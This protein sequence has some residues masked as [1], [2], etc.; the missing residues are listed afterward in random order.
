M[1]DLCFSAL[2]SFAA[3]ASPSPEDHV[4][5]RAAIDAVLDRAETAL[6][7]RDVDGVLAAYDPANT[8]LIERTRNQ[9]SGAIALPDLS[10]SH[11]IARLSGSGEDAEAVVLRDLRYTDHGRD[12]VSPTWRTMRFHRSAAGW[13]IVGDDERSFARCAE[14]DLRVELR[15]DLG[16]MEGT[17]A[18]RVEILADGE[19]S[20]VLGLNRGL[21]VTSVVDDKGRA[22]PFDRVA[23]NLSVRD[24]GPLRSG[25]VRQITIAFRGELFNDSQEQGYSQV[26]LAPEG[27]FAS[28]VTYWYPRLRGDGSKSKGKL[29]FTVPAGTI[30]ASN[31][32]L[33]NR[34]THGDRETQVFAV[35]RP[36]DFSFAAAKYF[37][38][39]QTI[40]GM[41]LGVYLLSGG[42]AKADLYLKECARALH[43]EIGFF[44]AYPFD[45]YALV[46]I[47]NE[48]TGGL[49]GS[50]EQGMNLFPVGV[51]PDG[52]FP[53]LLVGH[54]VG[55]S[56][57]GNLVQSKQ[58]EPI[59]DEGLAQTGAALTLRELEGEKAMRSW[60]YR[61]VPEY[62]QSARQYFARFAS[63]QEPDLAL[64]AIASGSDAASA[65]HDIADTK[66]VCVYAMLRDRI[67]HDAFVKA[68]RD[69]AVSFAKKPVGI[70]DLQAA[71]EKTSGKKLDRFFREWFF[72]AGAPEFVMRSSIDPA[73]KGFTVS[74]SV[75]QS[76][77]PYEADA[78]IALAFTGRTEKRSV[79]VDG[80]S[81]AFSF[82]TDEKPLFVAFDPEHKLLRWTSE[83]RNASLLRE[84]IGLQGIG[85]HDEAFEKLQAFVDKAPDSLRGRCQLGLLF[86]DV[87]DLA[88]AEECFRDV[89]DRSRAFDVYEPAVSTSALHLGQVLDLAGRREE[90]KKAYE[91]ALELPDEA[92][93]RKAAESGLAAPYAPTPR[94]EA[95]KADAL[96][97]Y[98]GTYAN[99]RGVEI[100]VAV[101]AQGVL[102]LQQKGGPTTSLVWSEGAKF[103][104]AGADNLTVEFAG[105]DAITAADVAWGSNVFHLP[106]KP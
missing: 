53:L 70:P 8:E 67:G 62:G 9:A 48:K 79:H 80:A 15:P 35:D 69:V 23:G 104:V 96:A 16:R 51:L 84:G 38:R 6:R 58:G 75:E 74:G 42:E 81:T 18:L 60:L 100:L 46:E 68:L 4:P 45:G 86:Q 73:E 12:Q 105:S 55:H 39:E 65:A 72:R 83:I 59:L 56:W 103:R 24:P 36:L 52:K 85:K 14:T 88:H 87:G 26:S 1:L 77:E 2:A 101:D 25:D 41:Q 106:R 63:G 31:G 20:L 93:S 32:R 33:A 27:S 17:A 19:D 37:H 95:P 13:L 47:P 10:I 57:W 102:T 44:G 43:C 82:R 49:G 28:W 5:D 71:F 50:S 40:D 34:E 22:L 91:I 54:E 61:G 92:G 89:T 64:G 98:A 78:E 30:V 7:A 66:G 90:A 21:D 99:D 97:R 29:S 94:S 76:G 11:R 3:C